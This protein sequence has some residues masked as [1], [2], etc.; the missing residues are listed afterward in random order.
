MTK[1]Q[2]AKKIRYTYM[3]V[4]TNKE[5]S[6]FGT[7][8]FGKHSTYKLDDGYIASG[9]KIRNYLSKYPNDY[10]RQIIKFYDTDEELNK[11]EHDLVKLHLGRP[12]CLNL[13]HGGENGSS[14]TE[15]AKQRISIATKIAMSRPEVKKKL[16]IK[17]EKPAWNKGKKG[18][19]EETRKKL[20]ESHKG[21]TH[22]ASEETRKKIGDALRGK[23]GWTHTTS[24]ETRKKIG[25]ALRGRTGHKHSEE[26]KRKMR[27]AHLGKKYKKKQAQNILKIKNGK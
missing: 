10:Y 18:V 27:E 19:S 6:M 25:D 16:K 2:K 24:E 1:Q 26:T 8:Y 17:R 9:I 14:Y 11:A 20:S 3:V 23:G 7:I 12:Y 13:K 4:P 22:T 15:E 5:S 21:K